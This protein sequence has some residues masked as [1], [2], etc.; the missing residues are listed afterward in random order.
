VLAPEVVV[1]EALTEKSGL[2]TLYVALTRATQRL[3]VLST[4]AEAWLD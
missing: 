2:R 3:V 4:H 1:T